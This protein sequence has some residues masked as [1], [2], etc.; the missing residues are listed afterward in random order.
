MNVY[1]DPR[2]AR[3]RKD[4][5]SVLAKGLF[6]LSLP[7]EVFA[8]LAASGYLEGVGIPANGYCQLVLRVGIPLV[9]AAWLWAGSIRTRVS[10][11][12]GNF[13]ALALFL[14]VLH[15]GRRLYAERHPGRDPVEVAF[16][17]ALGTPMDRP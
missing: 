10:R 13:M 4:R 11:T 9:A 3:F 5:E 7:A 6:A 8:L 16:E 1:D 12:A 15:E 14:L 17:S 2:F